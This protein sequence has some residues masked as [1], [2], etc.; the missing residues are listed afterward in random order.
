MRPLLKL[1]DDNSAYAV[2]HFIPDSW[3]RKAKPSK[4]SAGRSVT[5]KKSA[6]PHNIRARFLQPMPHAWMAV[7][8][9]RWIDLKVNMV[10]PK[11]QI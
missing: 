10:D 1:V 2:R 8:I 7:W 9:P 6:A 5:Y 11:E 4:R 3:A